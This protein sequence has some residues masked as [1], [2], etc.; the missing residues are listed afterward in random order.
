MTELRVGPRG[1]L[2]GSVRVPGD[3]SISHR[4]L[5]LSAVARGSTVIRGLLFSGD[6]ASTANALGSMGVHM[7]EDEHKAWLKVH[8]KG[9][10]ALRAPEGELD[11]GNSGTGMRLL[12][13][14]LAGLNINAVLTGDQSLLKRPMKRII[15]PLRLMG[16][17]IEAGPDDTAPLVIKGADLAGIRY[18]MEVA[19]AQVKSA[20]LL[21]GL[22]ARGETWVHEPAVTRDH[23]ER[24]MEAFG[25]K[26]ERKQGWAGVIGGQVLESPGEIEVPGDISAAAFFMVAALVVPGSEIVIKDV[27]VNPA[28]SGVLDILKNM[29]AGLEIKNL[30]TAGNEPVADIEVR[31]SRLR[32]TEVKGPLVPR[33]IDELPVICVAAARAEG[34]TVIREASELRVKESDRIAAMAGLLTAMGARVKEFHDGIEVRGGARLAG[35]TVDP[36]MDH[37][38][39]MAAAVAALCAKGQTLIRGAE[40]ISTSFPDFESSLTQATR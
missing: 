11:L 8:G 29:R 40:T 30:R 4:A 15:E 13:G 6:V 32:G 35:T 21:A 23:T 24:M 12:A 17:R 26:V 1:P 34:V 5:M 19:S 37:R 33:A 16:A 3:K 25:V 2:K 28:R 31:S 10:A 18:N 20:I 14:L 27:G 39:A 36:Q 22:S 9:P 7:E 38:V